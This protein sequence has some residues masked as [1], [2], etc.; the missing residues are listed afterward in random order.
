MSDPV[1]GQRGGSKERTNIVARL[2]RLFT[3]FIIE[4]F[5]IVVGRC[6]VAIEEYLA[7][8][9]VVLGEL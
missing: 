9:R 4:S 8:R 5:R 3:F 6:K 2:A 7:T 1:K